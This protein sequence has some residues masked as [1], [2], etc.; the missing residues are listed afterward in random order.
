MRHRAKA[1]SAGPDQRQAA[2]LGRVVRGAFGNHAPSEGVDGSG[3]SSGGPPRR[4]CRR[5]GFLVSLAPLAVLLAFAI[6][7]P[8]ASATQYQRPFKE[9]LG[10]EAQPT[11]TRAE[12]I[13]VDHGTGDVLVGVEGGY[14]E[15]G[16][17]Y[18]YHADGT[19][20]PFT[21][22]DSN[23]IDGQAGPGGKACA[24][25]PASCDRTPQ[26]ILELNSTQI[27]VD[28][29]GGVDNGDIYVTEAGAGVV[30][31]FSSEGKYLGQL[32]ARNFEPLNSPCGVAVDGGDNLYV[33]DGGHRVSKFVPTANPPTNSDYTTA[34]EP[35]VREGLCRLATGEGPSS[36]WIFAA[37]TAQDFSSHV[38]KINEATGE[39]TD[40]VSGYGTKIG[41]DPINGNLIA[42]R[43][44]GDQSHLENGITSGKELA[45]FS[46]AGQTAGSPLST[47][48]VEKD[49]PPEV[50]ANKENARIDDFALDSGGNVDVVYLRYGYELTHVVVYSANRA[51]VPTVEANLAAKIAGKTAVL[52]GAVNPS[53]VAVSECYFEY[54]SVNSG[55]FAEYKMK[56]P[57]EGSIPTDSNEHAVH[58][59]ISGLE[60]NGHE[61]VVRLVARNENG[62]E[63]ST[64]KTFLTAHTVNTEKAT[65]ITRS[66]ATLN[67]TI[68]PEGLEYSEC[69]F[70][71]GLNSSPGY[72]HKTACNPPAAAIE[73]GAESQAVSATLAELQRNSVY[74]F[75]LVATNTEGTQI[76]E[77]LTFTTLGLPEF[78]DV[79]ARDAS[80][81]GVTLEARINP[82]GSNTSYH[83]EWGPTTSYG[84]D[85]PADF[86]PA[87]GAGTEP[88]RVTAKVTGLA[89]AS[90]YH[91]RVVAT[92]SAGTANSGDQEA[93]TLDSCGMPDGRCY[94]LVSPPDAG[95]V[96]VPGE[97]KAAIEMISQAAT[98]GPGALAYIVE[99]GFPDSTTGAEILYLNRRTPSGWGDST[100]LKPPINAADERSGEGSGSGEVLAL[101]NDLSCGVV[102][103]Y[104]P[105]T[106]DP[107]AA[108][109]REAGGS[110]L[111]E[112]DNAS[113][114]AYRSITKLPPESPGV[115]KY[116]VLGMS[117]NCDTVVFSTE[118]VYPGIP[119]EGGT[120]LY[121]WRNGKL[122][123]LG[124][125]P[126]SSGE[127]VTE[128]SEPGGPRNV[129]SE[130]G[131]R[132]FFDATRKASSRNPAEIGSQ[133]VFMHQNGGATVDVSLSQTTTADTGATFQW[134]TPDGSKVFF[135]ANA[136]LTSKSNVS[137]TD[138]YEYD[139]TSGTLTDLSIGEEPG[140]A[141]VKGF[142][143]GSEDGSRVY[144]LAQGKL[145]PG[146]GHGSTLSKNQANN[147]EALYTEANGFVSFVATVGSAE[148]VEIGESSTLKQ[149][150]SRVTPDGRYL[151][152][153]TR[154]NVTGYESDGRP[155]AYLYDA[156]GGS[157]G[158][159][160]ISCRPDGLPPTAGTYA[161]EPLGDVS[162][163][164]L[165]PLNV[166]GESEGQ[167][168]VF[169]LS[170]DQLAPGALENGP[171][172]YEWT[173]GQVFLIESELPGQIEPLSG[174]ANLH[175]FGVSANG[176][177]VYF[178]TRRSLTW[179]DGDERAS[180]Y[181]AR[182]GGG[183]PEPAPSG[184][185]SCDPDA[186]RSCLAPTAAPS[187]PTAG[188]A[189]YSGPGNPKSTPQHP[190]KKHKKTHK[191]HKKKGQKK[192]RRQA[193]RR[194]NDNRRAGK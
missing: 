128:A 129:V 177:D 190:K 7:A 95:P 165:H 54:G 113:P 5:R 16:R 43:V 60:P 65:E 135:T 67:G 99:T 122:T 11:F 57:C 154:Q 163:N 185:S 141:E 64:P 172:L 103:S 88:V 131:S 10:S 140:P 89:A 187:T 117:Q 29:S 24:E 94:E 127:E 78:S 69:F 145:V 138:L 82:S 22:L 191:K 32:T 105:L 49:T 143:G 13:A 149:S 36:G 53:G 73:S 37:Y 14:N 158:V 111:Y 23:M 146:K 45:E 120:R 115:K 27:T 192:K 148:E 100:Q 173:H 93:E 101:S 155:V 70:E 98:G 34:F 35:E 79:G 108:E 46:T 134:A 71:W 107:G 114:P 30:D 106:E 72:G 40:F 164:V 20:A 3:A 178:S 166:I 133:G 74:H 102:E 179:E 31:I 188:S 61:Y 168:Q 21:A 58:A 81:N 130:D 48:V 125:V 90:V 123:N 181:D 91:Y 41:I 174:Y 44:T 18:R 157:A 80:Q 182:V 1:S 96:A 56:A 159:T 39:S 162:H 161:I 167:A 77:D 86:E 194:A 112:S 8:T 68:L 97:H 51:I 121:E 144:F 176:S 104:M 136:G 152:F 15:A 50:P 169:F 4:A 171:S 47:V 109:N 28:S 52:T 76:G 110:N 118:A 26:N 139:V 83:F 153:Q 137:G 183:F 6:A 170:E 42:Q 124:L 193:R 9:A 17:I 25:E 150:T 85:V 38:A 186:E 184:G 19:P 12:V 62:A 126:G 142:V 119:G 160:C 87:I 84:N 180:V 55:G 66:T 75:R 92:N 132:I 189:S 151:A 116:T 147:T 156:H 2:G 33:S 59:D 63:R 175:V